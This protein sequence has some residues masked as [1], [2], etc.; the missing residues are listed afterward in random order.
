MIWW[1][2][3]LAETQL[4]KKPAVTGYPIC[5][6]AR[7]FYLHHLKDGYRYTTNVSLCIVLYT[8]RARDSH[9]KSNVWYNVP[10]RK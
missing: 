2:A 8:R 4:A 7:H 1:Q 6:A 3:Q 10:I 5:P 9:I